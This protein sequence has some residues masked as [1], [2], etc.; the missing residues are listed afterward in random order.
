MQVY[1]IQ[2]CLSIYC[3]GYEKFLEMEMSVIEKRH[4]TV[5]LDK[6]E[7]VRT[8]SPACCAPRQWADVPCHPDQ[9]DRTSLDPTG[10][11]VFK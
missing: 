4:M 7:L 9:K 2:K 10:N 5:G 1:F 3:N 8:I 11:G 6:A